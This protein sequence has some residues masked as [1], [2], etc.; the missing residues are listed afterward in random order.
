VSVESLADGWYGQ[1]REILITEYSSFF[2]MLTTT[3][4][5]DPEV[6]RRAADR[7]NRDIGNYR[8]RA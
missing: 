2:G 1:N 3:D 4:R 5:P 8:P 7:S 6:V